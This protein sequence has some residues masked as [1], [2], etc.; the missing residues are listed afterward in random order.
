MTLRRAP[1]VAMALIVGVALAAPLL[2]IASPLRM[3]VAHRMASPS[4][5]HPLGLDEFGRDE[6]SR[7]LWG[8]RASL[9]VAF[10]SS[11]IAGAIGTMIGV[12]G[13]FLRGIV[14][15]VL[16]RAVDVVLC[17]P[18]LLLALLVVTL[19]GPGA[20]TLILVLSVL[21]LPGFARVA[22]AGTLSVRAQSFVEAVRALGASRARIMLRTIL[23]NIVGPVLV[24]LSLAAASAI[25]LESGLSFL[26]LGVVPPTPSWGLA[27]GAARATMD[28]APLLLLWP[29]LALTAT[30]LAM[31]ALCDALRDAFEPHAKPR[32]VA[33][34]LRA[35]IL[36]PRDAPSP[37]G[38]LL[39]IRDLTITI[40]TPRG[41]AVPVRGVSLS[42][43]SGETL[44]IVGESGSGKTLTGLSILGLLPDVAQISSGSISFNGTDLRA[45]EAA[46]WRR[47]RGGD[48]AM[49][50]QDPMSSLNPLHRVGAQV[51]E[52]IAA[53]KPLPAREAQARAVSLLQQVGI[54]DAKRRASAFPH[55]M[56][57]GMRQRVMIAMAIANNPR[58]VIAD[59][60]TASL[61]VTIQAQVLDLFAELKRHHDLALVFI[62]HSLPVVA[63]VADRVAVMYAG[64]VV[65]EGPVDA[66]FSAPLH[67]YTAA[68]MASAPSK[69]GKPLQAIGGTVPSPD[70]V[71][72]GCRFAPRCVRRVE[73]CEASPAPMIEVAPGRR[74]RCLRWAEL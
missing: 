9:V 21:F 11:L 31:N 26:G 3:D 5:A 48:V 12:V 15:Q 40:P 63:E 57:G 41:M 47:L 69:E 29:S 70:V 17:F 34:Y 16:L 62:S 74:S 19:L 52:A 61:D 64:E 71:L 44:A 56:S 32:S 67:P 68:L 54:P 24:Q 43:A 22:Y 28:Q 27:I 30:I 58:L 73:R 20:Q 10:A 39:D 6:L 65:E 14:E 42:V 4:W 36:A 51:A 55:E 38:K 7:I 53:H 37:S 18:P 1:F 60:P 35:A 50:F 45:I 23:P 66:V 25:I 13:G 72:P 46:G 2:P 33:A 8:G 59:E 49:V